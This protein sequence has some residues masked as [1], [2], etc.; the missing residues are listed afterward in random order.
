MY[1]CRVSNYVI[2]ITLPPLIGWML[3]IFVTNPSQWVR[4]ILRLSSYQPDS[5][6]RQK[7]SKVEKLN[8]PSD[9]R[10]PLTIYLSI[11]ILD[12]PPVQHKKKKHKP[13][14]QD[15]PEIHNS[16]CEQN[17]LLL[18]LCRHIPITRSPIHYALSFRWTAPGGNIAGLNFPWVRWTQ[19]P[20]A[21]GG[22]S[23]QNHMLEVSPSDT[24]GGPRRPWHCRHL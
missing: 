3:V 5:S 15:M 4:V 18:L 21:A 23:A 16:T 11:W 10:P 19:V 17:I 20:D 24:Q 8:T 22:G 2:D 6:Q 13:R 12:M 1:F 7:K 14:K 9:S